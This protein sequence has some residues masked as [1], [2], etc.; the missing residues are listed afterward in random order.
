MKLKSIVI[1]VQAALY[2]ALLCGCGTPEA[3]FYPLK[4]DSPERFGEHIPADKVEL[5]ITKKPP[6]K[7]VELGMVTFETPSSFADEP[8]IY[9]VMREKAGEIGADGLI[10]MTSQSS[11]EDFPRITLDY[12]GYPI[13]TNTIRSYIKY[14]G[15]A[16]KKK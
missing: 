3:N 2:L 9:R 8:R 12:Y 15:M 7:Y 14:R 10:I 6:Y 1:E 4:S 13:E 11:A 5:F 16:I